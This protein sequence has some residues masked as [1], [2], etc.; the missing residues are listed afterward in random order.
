MQ[1][2]P[3]K[4]IVN[5][6]EQYF[7]EIKQSL[8]ADIQC[9]IYPDENFTGRVYRV[10]PIID[11]ISRTF[12]VEI[13]IPNQNVKLRPGMYAKVSLHI[14]KSEALLVPSI[15]V[16]KLQGSNVKYLFINV[17]GR[18]KMV[19]VKIGKRFDDQLEV[20]AEELYE[21]VQVIITGQS[22]LVD[23]TPITISNNI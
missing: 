6:S 16:L 5:I 19:E 11:P 15:A 7:P 23:D 9:D 10:H 21:G 4:A 2:N 12:Q 13:S 3:L 17:D 1:V 20:S 8:K 18:A 22:K 14:G